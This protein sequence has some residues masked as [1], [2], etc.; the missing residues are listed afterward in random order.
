MGVVY[1]AIRDSDGSRIAL[2]TIK[3]QGKTT[4]ADIQRFLREASILSELDHP[5]IVAFRERGENAGLLYFAME[6]VPGVD[7]SQLQKD[8]GGPLAPPRA[9]RIISQLLQ[10]LEYAHTKGFVH[11][12]I[13]PANILVDTEAGRETVQ[14][15]DFGLARVYQTSKMSGLTMK[16]DLGGTFAFMAPEQ[17]TDLRD[18][19]PPVDQYSAG[20]TLYKLLTDRYIYDMPSHYTAQIQTILFNDPIPILSRRPNLPQGLAEVI[21]RSLA[22]DP[23]AR[24]KDVREMRR[25]LMAFG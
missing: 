22:R 19:R 17:V 18:A 6:Y 15:S 20:A 4:E 8:H 5:H 12:D 2:K 14:L 7:A 24:F 25:A 23:N 16:G 9:V 11:R 1:L 21:H 10:A 3:P 13:K